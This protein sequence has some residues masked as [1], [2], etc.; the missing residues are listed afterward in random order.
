[1]CVHIHIPTYVYIYFYIQDTS[2]FEFHISN[3]FNI[4]PHAIFTWNSNLA[5]YSVYFL[6]NL[7]LKSQCG[8][9]SRKVNAVIPSPKPET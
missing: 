2:K 4:I 5:R 1:M 6:A 3:I 9:A 8:K 7:F